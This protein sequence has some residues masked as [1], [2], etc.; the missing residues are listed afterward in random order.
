M[1]TVSEGFFF[2][3]LSIKELRPRGMYGVSSLQQVAAGSYGSN[4]AAAGQTYSFLP[5]MKSRM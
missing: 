2:L 1:G 4:G 3:S 5:S